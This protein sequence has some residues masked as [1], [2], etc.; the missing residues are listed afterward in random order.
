MLQ[1]IP[2]RGG[3]FLK[4]L[5][6][7]LHFLPHSYHPPI[8]PLSFKLKMHVA[9]LRWFFVAST[10]GFLARLV[11]PHLSLLGLMGAVMVGVLGMLYM[12]RLTHSER[13]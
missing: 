4:L 9:M 2:A 3:V 10:S 6:S 5:V 12:S 1:F 11:D 7:V 13:I 8:A